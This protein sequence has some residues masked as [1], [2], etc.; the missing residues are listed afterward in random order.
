MLQLCISQQI[1]NTP[2][3]FNGTGIRVY[4][5]E[6]ALYHAYH[7]WRESVD[8]LLS[9]SLTAWMDNQGLAHISAKMKEIAT[10]EPLSKRLPAFLGIIEY[11]SPA[12][13]HSIKADLEHWEHRVEWE[14]LKDRA[15]HMVSRGEPAKAIPLYLSALKYD[16]IDSFPGS[17]D[18]PHEGHQSSPNNAILLNNLAIAHMQLSNHTEAAS[19]LARAHAAQPDNIAIALHYAE[20]A[21]LNGDYETAKKMLQQVEAATLRGSKPLQHTEA[22]DPQVDKSPKPM[23]TACLH[24]NKSPKNAETA[25]DILFLY[26]LIAYQQ[27]DYPTAL[28][29]FNQAKAQNPGIAYYTHKIADTYVQMHQHDRAL[30]VLKQAPGPL[31]HVKMAEIYAAYGHAHMPEA[32]RHIREAISQG[33]PNEA[34]L[35]TK[36]AEYYRKDYDWQR[37][38]EAI[39]H[40]LPSKS[41]AA[42]LENAR[43]KKG[44]GRMREYRA[45]LSEALKGIKERYPRLDRNNINM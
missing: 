14:K 45:G 9:E 3:T 11:F 24:D 8:E 34:V 35:W 26:G 21:I 4:S 42:L 18:A 2:Y 23:E 30:A 37:A 20:A 16:V 6:E 7:Y 32:I 36:L 17:H 19:L 1:S 31:D 10:I 15:D 27:K 41:D 40:A 13:L 39:S 38:D 28:D 25:A 12:E 29:Y 44:L 5:I 22:V 33:G 43:I